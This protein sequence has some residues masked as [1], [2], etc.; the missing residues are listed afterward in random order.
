MVDWLTIC[1]WFLF[2]GFWLSSGCIPQ[3]PSPSLPGLWKAAARLQPSVAAAAH[4]SGNIPPGA[5]N[6]CRVLRKGAMEGF[7]STKGQM[8]TL[9]YMLQLKVR[10]LQTIGTRPA[11]HFIFMAPISGESEV[12]T[13]P[14]ANCA[15]PTAHR[16]RSQHPQLNLSLAL[17][18]PAK[19]AQAHGKLLCLAR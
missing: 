15:G 11:C 18:S 6:I 3:P 4:S 8:V 2:L 13:M 16:A 5:P 10:C 1:S 7:Q 9:Q 12:S 14:M 17:P 19:R